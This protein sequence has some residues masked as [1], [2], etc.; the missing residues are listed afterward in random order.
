MIYFVGV[1]FFTT[2]STDFHGLF[3]WR[4]FL[5]PSREGVGGVL[6]YIIRYKVDVCHTPLPLSRGELI[7]STNASRDPSLHYVSLWMTRLG[8]WLTQSKVKYSPP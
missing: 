1:S 2:D 4:M 3:I 8:N 7:T 5:L 6:E